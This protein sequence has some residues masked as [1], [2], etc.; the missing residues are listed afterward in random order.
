MDLHQEFETAHREHQDILEF[1]TVWEHALKLLESDNL[2]LRCEALHQLQKMEQRIAGICDHC[3]R[4]E[5]DPDSPL[6]RFA[7]E[8]DRDRLKDEHFHLH[9]ANYQFR[10]EME[11]TTTSDTSDLVFLGHELLSALRSH[12]AFEDGLLER[13]KAEQS[14]P[15]A[16]AA[17]V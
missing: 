6:F 13:F 1:L 16:A 2:D 15:L 4:E 14:A 3:R 17:R 9:Q 8:S 12:V 7:Q 11:F 10:K 5:E